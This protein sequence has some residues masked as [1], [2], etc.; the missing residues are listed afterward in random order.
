MMNKTLRALVASFVALSLAAPAWG[1]NDDVPLSE[2]VKEMPAT[3]DGVT[4]YRPAEDNGKLQISDL[5][6]LPNVSAETI[7]VN[8]M[9]DVKSNFNAEIEEIN[10][11]DYERM[12]FCLVRSVDDADHVA[13]YNYTIAVQTTDGIM[14]FLVTDI[15]IGY[16]EKGILPRTLAIEKMKPYKDKRHK[17]L[18]E[19]CAVSISKYVNKLASAV[20]SQTHPAVTHW[21]DIYQGNVTKGMNE[22]EVMLVKGRPDSSRQ[23]NARTKWMYGNDNVIIFTDGVVT[24]IIQ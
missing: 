6:D 15:S 23:S 17:E 13:T 7:F 22:T 1:A 9:V 16:K 11:V 5:V 10:K 14:T 2:W 24:N 21:Q 19:Q 4:I 20:T 3:I 18:I 8:T 12:R